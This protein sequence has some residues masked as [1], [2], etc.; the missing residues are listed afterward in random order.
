M[1]FDLIMIAALSLGAYFSFHN[2]QTLLGSFFI[3]LVLLEVL[4]LW[5]NMRATRQQLR[6]EYLENPKKK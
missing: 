4:V 3:V 6:D 2:G 5:K 1:I